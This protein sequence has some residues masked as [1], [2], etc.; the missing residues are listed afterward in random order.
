[1]K[2]AKKTDRPPEQPNKQLNPTIKKGKLAAVGR[3]RKP[4]GNTETSDRILDCAEALFSRH[5]F[6]GVTVRLVAASAQVD[7]ALAHYYFGTKERMFN[8]VFE[9][10][11]QILNLERL[12]A[13]DRYE[14][15]FG[16]E[17][18]VK[19]IISAFLMP[20]LDPVRH[21]DIG[22]KN[23][24]ALAAQVNNT[25]EWGAETMT[26]YFDPVVTRMI[27]LLHRAMPHAR[28][29]DLFWSYHLMTGSLTLTLSDTRRLDR[30]SQGLC[31][32]SD[33]A[34]IGPRLID[35]CVSGFNTL[36]GPDYSIVQ[37]S[38]HN[39]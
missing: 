4:N 12:E 3:P 15:E 21:N 7:T 14:Y 28:K 24:F 36:C 23:Y 5:G 16:S 9:R 6:Y 13:M 1:M 33:I 17:M 18:T 22:W 20:L 39:S 32:S 35:Y 11:A 37:Q 34:S 26:R 10:R 29:E 2:P 30:L 38:G 8:A 31:H 27:D 19:G 25:P